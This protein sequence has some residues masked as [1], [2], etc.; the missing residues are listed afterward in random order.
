MEGR[1]KLYDLTLGLF[2]AVLL[3]SNIASTKIVSIGPFTFD[4]GTLLFPIVYIFGDVVTE[5][6]G[7]KGSRRIIWTGFFALFLMS[8][9]I[10][11]VGLIPPAPG[12]NL[13]GAY[14][15][16]LMFAPRIA[17]ASM[18]A[19]CLGEFTNSYIL[20]RMKNLTKG[21]HLWARTIGSTVL[22]EFVDTVVFC[23]LAFW[24]VVPGQLL[25]TI[26]ISNYVF[27]VL[28]EVLATPLTYKVVSYY[29]ETEGVDVYDDEYKI[30]RMK[31]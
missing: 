1:H 18:I 19:Y 22:G 21:R 16:I 14:E 6:Y 17:I 25:L 26:I 23:M 28:F 20:S 13:Q 31:N 30:F 9:V 24:G 7:F 27:K 12:W 11:I 2:V 5:V 29:K 10:W 3:I 8:I 15:S 4:G